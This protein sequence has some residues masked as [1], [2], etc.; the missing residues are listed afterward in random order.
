M[1]IYD[2]A[3]ELVALPASAVT[4]TTS[5]TGVA[6]PVRMLPT[7]DW[8]IYVTAIDAVSTDETYVFTL[9]VSDLVGGTYTAIASHNYPRGHGAGS[10][11]IPINGDMASFQDTDSAFC[12]VTMTSGGTTP[13][14]R[15]GSFLTK[16]SNK[17]GLAR[18]VLDIVT[19][20]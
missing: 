10:I 5:S 11:H 3:T 6:I 20:P 4:T 12:R 2:V 7:S 17:L 16:T 1:P 9:E 18:D 13:S 15:F 19:F 8:V 14:I